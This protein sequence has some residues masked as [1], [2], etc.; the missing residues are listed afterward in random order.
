MQ[1][2]SRTLGK[3]SANARY[4]LQLAPALVVSLLLIGVIAFGLARFMPTGSTE[5]WTMLQAVVVT[6]T[7]V[8]IAVQA[9][10]AVRQ[11]DQ[12][13]QIAR[14]ERTIVL[15]DRASTI[16]LGQVIR[17]LRQQQNYVES[18]R[19]LGEALKSDDNPAVNRQGERLEDTL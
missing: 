4:L 5:Y 2:R 15:L 18:G 8:F 19:A 14:I 9:H 16:R 11:L 7:L 13:D 17:R 12:N 3:S 10:L 1:M 6:V